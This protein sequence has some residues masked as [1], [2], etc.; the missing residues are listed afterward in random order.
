MGSIF[1]GSSKPPPPDTSDIDARESKLERQETEEKRKIA[2]RSKARRAG[3]SN[4]LM[5]QRLLVMP[6]TLETHKTLDE[7]I[8]SQ[9]KV[10]RATY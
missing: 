6:E 1:G 5:T 9:S 3:G 2:S 7:K 4:M 8:Y 10:Q